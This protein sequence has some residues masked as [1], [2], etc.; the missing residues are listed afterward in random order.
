[1]K[2][3]IVILPIGSFAMNKYR[4]GFALTICLMVAACYVNPK[5]DAGTKFDTDSGA[6]SKVETDQDGTVDFTV[7]ADESSSDSK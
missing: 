4:L 7:P 3:C 5:D 2:V 1:M 6:F